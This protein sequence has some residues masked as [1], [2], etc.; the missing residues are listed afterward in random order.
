MPP[1]GGCFAFLAEVGNGDDGGNPTFVL[2]ATMNDG[3]ALRPLG[4]I[5]LLPDF[6]K[7]FLVIPA[8]PDNYIQL[9]VP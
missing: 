6:I 8:S 1:P 5:P 3:S 7:D 9:K 2:T 4:T